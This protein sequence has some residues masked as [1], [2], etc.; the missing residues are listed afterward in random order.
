MLSPYQL[1][2]YYR[3][4]CVGSWRATREGARWHS[5]LE[6][7]TI[8]VV[9]RD[10]YDAIDFTRRALFLAYVTLRVADYNISA[11]SRSVC[12]PDVDVRGHHCTDVRLW[13]FSDITRRPK[14]VGFRT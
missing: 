5:K 4:E 12:R 3:G 13:P 8:P 10:V 11:S 7:D 14:D 6:E 9:V 1:T 2:I